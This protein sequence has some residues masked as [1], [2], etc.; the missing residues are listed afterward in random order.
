MIR[1]QAKRQ[2]AKRTMLETLKKGDHIVTIGGVHGTVVGFKNQGKIVVIKV[3][4]NTNLSVVKSSIAGLAD[5]VTD[6][7][8]RIEA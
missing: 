8:T 1:P 7:D 5:S 2:K 3:D 6:Q 4:K